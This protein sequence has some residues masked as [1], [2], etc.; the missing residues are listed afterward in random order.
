[1]KKNITFILGGARSG[2][3]EYALKLA[4]KAKKV[5]FIATCEALDEEMESRIRKH[6][7]SRPKHWTSLE[8]PLAVA[9]AI[10]KCSGENDLILIDCLTLLV[11]NLL[12]KDKTME[13]IES[14]MYSIIRA[15][16]K[17]KGSS[18]V[19]SNE[20][21]LGIVPDNKLG[22]QFRDIAGMVNKIAAQEAD[23][24]FFMVSGIPWRIK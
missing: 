15:L 18:V 3:S 1:M 23:R 14:E 24:V 4:S 8:E 19:V 9:G 5:A 20:V 10:N 6:K 22:R 17:H 21:G 12:L 13:E 16:K 2:K 7:S 11:T